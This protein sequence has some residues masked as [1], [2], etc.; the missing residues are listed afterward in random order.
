[1]KKALL[2]IDMQNEMVGEK[3]AA[4]FKYDHDALIRSVNDVIDANESS[5]VIYIQHLMK[6]NL[7]NNFA[8]FHTYE[9]TDSAE[10]VRDLHVVS[11]HFFSKYKGNAFTNPKLHAFLKEHDIECV[12]VVGVDGGWC[13]ALTALG[14]V[15]AGYRVIVNESAIGTIYPKRKEKFFKRLKEAD[16]TFM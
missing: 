7:I 12:E 16:V 3:H 14:A 13:V 6:K 15:K 8:S 11:G 10:L 4:P 5:L 9:G 2:V 1:M